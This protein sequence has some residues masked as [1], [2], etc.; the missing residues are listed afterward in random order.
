M[1]VLV[2]WAKTIKNSCV[3][4]KEEYRCMMLMLTR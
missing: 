3:V 2:L 1:D 4:T